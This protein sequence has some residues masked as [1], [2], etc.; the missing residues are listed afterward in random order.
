MA[1]HL[2]IFASSGKDMVLTIW[3]LFWGTGNDWEEELTQQARA[4]TGGYHCICSLTV[5]LPLQPTCHISLTWFTT[6]ESSPWAFL[7]FHFIQGWIGWKSLS[8]SVCKLSNLAAEAATSLL[9]CLGLQ[10]MDLLKSC[11]F[12]SASLHAWKHCLF[13]FLVFILRPILMNQLAS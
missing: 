10:Q 11:V 3:C 8:P 2:F 1:S 4:L 6:K 13:F 5:P 7:S 12:S 9:L